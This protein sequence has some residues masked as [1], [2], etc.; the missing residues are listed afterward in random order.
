MLQQKALSH[1]TKYG[2]L[3]CLT[4]CFFLS[5]ISISLVSI[6][7]PLAFLCVISS[8]NFT[9]QWQRIQSNKAALSFWLLAIPFIVGIFYSTSTRHFIIKDLIKHNWLLITP[10]LIA[11]NMNDRWRH[12]MINAFLLAMTITLLLSLSKRIFHLDY[13]A[14]LP[15]IR[16]SAVNLSSVFSYHLV[17]SYAMGIAAFI[18]V[19]RLFFQNTRRWLYGGLFIVMSINI[20]LMSGSKT[21][22]FTFLLLLMYFGVVRFGWKSIF[23]TVFLSALIGVGGFFL[24]TS[25]QTRVN[26]MVHDYQHYSQIHYDNSTSQRIEMYRFAKKMIGKR[27]WFG[28]GTGGIQTALP[29]IIPAKDRFFSPTTSYVESIYLNFLLEF[30]VVGL[31]VLFIAIAMQ[32]KTSL[33]LPHFYRYLIHVVLI[34]TLFGGLF[35][36]F[37]VSF[38]IT[39]M[40]ALFSAVCFGALKNKRLLKCE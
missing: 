22:Y 10:F 34:S 2:A 25:M 19:Y 26:Q 17:Q 23:Y 16:V 39:H 38:P 37:F 20:L 1:Y 6:L 5:Q 12:R 11:F 40:Y 13:H 18:C 32:I 33:Q 35:N 7:F 30:G 4:A 15:I 21:G 14:L 36:M 27:P 29:L 3:C 28:Y 31:L 8:D 24:S 9:A